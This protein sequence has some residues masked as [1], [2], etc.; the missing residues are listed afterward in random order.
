LT[1]PVSTVIIGCS[2]L[3]E[4]EENAG[5]ARTWS[6]YPPAEMARIEELARPYQEDA[7]FFKGWG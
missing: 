2:T 1:L 4:V 5:I 6:A 7:S 3:E